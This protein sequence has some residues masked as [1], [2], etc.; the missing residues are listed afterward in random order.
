MRKIVGM[1]LLA[2]LAFP[3]MVGAQS[4]DPEITG[5][6]VVANGFNGP[7][8]ITLD[9]DGNLWVI[10]SGQGGD[11][12]TM[13][14]SM[15][16]GQPA[17]TKMGLTAR[18]VRVAPDG[19]QTNEAMLPSI[20]SSEV[21]RIGGGGVAW[22]N[23]TLYATSGAWNGAIG[24]DAPDLVGS[25]VRLEEGA[26]SEV[27]NLWDYEETNNPDSLILDSHPYGIT[28]GPDGWLWIADSGANTLL[29]VN[30]DTGEIALVTA[31][32]GLPGSAPNPARS[33]A[34]ELDPVPTAVAFDDENTY[35]SLLSGYPFPPGA[36]KVVRITPDGEVTDYATGLTMPTDLQR[37]PDG[38]LYAVEFGQFNEQG[39]IPNM[40]SIVRVKEGTA[41]EVV[42]SG[43]SFPTSIA[44]DADGNAYVT[45]NGV[46]APESGAVV[47]F[48]ELTQMQ[49]TPISAGS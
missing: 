18:V 42:L 2:V 8:G 48:D 11:Q 40:G 21:E 9:A 44:F 20:V 41:S 31:F 32:A 16:T 4:P 34:M 46:G 47:R 49:G 36:G 6:T 38:E 45:V 28:A 19:T 37:G 25:V 5:G 23:G 1:V 33:G 17:L 3:A 10:D 24:T 39:P 43:L 7:Q 12:D 26:V 30:P 35:A 15:E 27:A 29:R 22:L 14:F 13:F